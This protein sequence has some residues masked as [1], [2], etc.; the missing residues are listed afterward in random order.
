[1]RLAV[2]GRIDPLRAAGMRLAEPGNTML[3]KEA[4][5]RRELLVCEIVAAAGYIEADKV[6]SHRSHD[7]RFPA[8]RP[9]CDAG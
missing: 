1:M 9:S 3:F 7:L 6:A 2:V 5:P 4:L 8:R